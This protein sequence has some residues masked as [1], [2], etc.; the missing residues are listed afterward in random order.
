MGV[1]AAASAEI[2]IRTCG[3]GEGDTNGK[4]RGCFAGVSIRLARPSRSLSENCILQN[5]VLNARV[6][7]ERSDDGYEVVE[8][9][10]DSL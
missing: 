2:T 8:G 5:V 6:V 10:R 1:D 7:M 3:P 9:N 4:F